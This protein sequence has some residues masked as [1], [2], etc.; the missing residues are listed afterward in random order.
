MNNWG[1][2]Q[3]SAVNSNCS[4]SRSF[5][6]LFHQSRVGLPCL[7]EF[8]ADCVVAVLELVEHECVEFYGDDL[9]FFVKHVD[10]FAEYAEAVSGV[11]AFS[12]FAFKRQGELLDNWRI[13]LRAF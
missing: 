9:A 12:D 1:C 10:D 4:E 13:H 11:L 6:S 7:S 3:H 8:F 5:R 2:R